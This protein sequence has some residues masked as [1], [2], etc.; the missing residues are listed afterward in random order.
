MTSHR[1]IFGDSG[2]TTY[3]SIGQ[4]TGTL[5]NV[6]RVGPGRYGLGNTV[7]LAASATSHI[8]FSSDV[9]QF[10]TADFTV[11]LW[12]K[13]TEQARYFDVVGNRTAPS[14]GNFFSMRMT[15]NYPGQPSGRISI[16]VDQDGNGTNYAHVEST[17]VN[18][19]DGKWHH[20]AAVRGGPSL[21]LYV[22]G[23]FAGQDAAKGVAAIKNGNPFRLGA[24]LSGGISP[25]AQY[26]DLGIF[27]RQIDSDEI[28]HIHCFH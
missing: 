5:T 24:S 13:T 12:L 1:F 19:N 23:A 14:H 20:V 3:D 6:S 11:A 4:A 10:G 26:F 2:N 27:D 17:I 25:N 8:D 16:E 21:T 7:Q 9:G 28:E 22:D 18:L 15:G